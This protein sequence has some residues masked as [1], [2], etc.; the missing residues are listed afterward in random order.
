MIFSSFFTGQDDIELAATEIEETA[1]KLGN[2]AAQLVV[3]PIYSSMPSELQQKIFEPTPL[4]ARKVILATNIA[5][6]SITVPGIR[7]VIDSGLA[8][9]LVFNPATGTESLQA[10]PISRAAAEQRAGRAGRV[11]PGTCLRLYTNA[12]LALGNARG[13]LSGHDQKQL[14]ADGALPKS[15]GY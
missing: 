13:D 3:A 4:G 6:T 11:G 14:V 8:K 2:R 15:N 12:Q 9:E 10:T 5:E 1:K 7:Y